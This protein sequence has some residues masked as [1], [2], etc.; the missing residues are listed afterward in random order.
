MEIPSPHLKVH[1]R[2]S[3]LFNHNERIQVI[4]DISLS[5]II[6]ILDTTETNQKIYVA[7]FHEI[8]CFHEEYQI[9]RAKENTAVQFVAGLTTFSEALAYAMKN[10]HI[11]LL[12]CKGQVNTCEICNNASD[13]LRNKSKS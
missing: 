10:D 9:S 1:S 12:R 8:N 5:L 13:L 3:L 6:K 2:Y 11:R 4:P 7:T